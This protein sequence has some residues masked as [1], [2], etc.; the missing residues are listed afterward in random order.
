MREFYGTKLIV[1]KKVNTSEK[2][3]QLNCVHFKKAILLFFPPHLVAQLRIYI[4][5][6]ILF[7]FGVLHIYKVN[8][9]FLSSENNKTSLEKK[10][11]IVKV[12]KH[13]EKENYV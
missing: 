6:K 8:I 4:F 10:R 9:F 7:L 13:K 11:G 1:L 12:R 5:S 3:I 2:K